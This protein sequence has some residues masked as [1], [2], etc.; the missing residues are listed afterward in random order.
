M[1][2]TDH[3]PEIIK[4]LQQATQDFT[5]NMLKMKP[6]NPRDPN[7]GLKIKQWQNLYAFSTAMMHQIND[8]ANAIYGSNRSDR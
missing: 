6:S 2:Y 3:G 4:L 1:P 5:N 7:Y 8:Q